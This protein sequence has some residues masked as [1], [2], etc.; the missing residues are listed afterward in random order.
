MKACAVNAAVDDSRQKRE[1]Y[2]GPPS[3]GLMAVFFGERQLGRNLAL[4]SP[5]T[6]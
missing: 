2:D 5:H 1:R 4:D 6:G 3:F